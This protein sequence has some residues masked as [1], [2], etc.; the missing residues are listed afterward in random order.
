MHFYGKYMAHMNRNSEGKYR[1]YKYF[2]KDENFKEIMFSNTDD[3]YM[4]SNNYEK[5]MQGM[6]LLT[7]QHRKNA[8][9]TLT[10]RDLS[11]YKLW[12]TR[13]PAIDFLHMNYENVL[14]HYITRSKKESLFVNHFQGDVDS[15]IFNSPPILNRIKWRR[16]NSTFV[17]MLADTF[18]LMKP[19]AIANEIERDFGEGCKYKINSGDTY[20]RALRNETGMDYEI[21]WTKWGN[22]SW[23]HLIMMR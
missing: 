21:L 11:Q 9:I 6:T 10:D 19:E 22:R 7:I 14:A 1:A 2:L 8:K 23:E 12:V 20:L 18:H 3:P 13:Y 16:P 4:Y 15:R 17:F 5:A